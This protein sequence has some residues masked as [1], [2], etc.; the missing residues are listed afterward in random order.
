MVLVNG[1][2]GWKVQEFLLESAWIN[3]SW[4]FQPKHW[5]YWN[6]RYWRHGRHRKIKSSKLRPTSNCRYWDRRRRVQIKQ[7]PGPLTH[8]SRAFHQRRH[9]IGQ[10]LRSLPKMTQVRLCIRQRVKR[11]H[12][13]FRINRISKVNQI[14]FLKLL[15]LLFFIFISSL[16]HFFNF[17]LY[18]FLPALLLPVLLSFSVNLQ[19]ILFQKFLLWLIVHNRKRVEL[20]RKLIQLTLVCILIELRHTL[21]LP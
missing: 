18:F 14:T 1:F 16:H 6:L 9:I 4:V 8:T 17:L 10:R 21:L 15:L 19:N 3:D 12:R 20:T 5:Y 11:H 13:V 2:C 7:P